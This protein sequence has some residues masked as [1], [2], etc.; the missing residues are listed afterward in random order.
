LDALGDAV[1]ASGARAQSEDAKVAFSGSSRFDEAKE[2][3]EKAISVDPNSFAAHYDLAR[4][5]AS[6]C[7][8]AVVHASLEA[9]ALKPA[10]DALPFGLAR[11]NL[12]LQIGTLVESGIEHAHRALEI[13]PNSSPAMQQLAGLLR[14]RADLD[15]TPEGSEA[16]RSL[17]QDWSRRAA[18]RSELAPQGEPR[19]VRIGARVAEANLTGRVDPVYPPLARAARVQG[20][21]EFTVTIDETGRVTDA[22]LVSGHPLLVQAAKEAVMQWMYRPTFL[23][24]QPVKVMTTVDVPFRLPE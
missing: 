21:V 9:G 17:S 19:F 14:I 16:D 4:I 1:Y 2:L 23:N 11:Q 12:R 15:E 7:V 22:K 3:L 8:P 10:G 5:I 20:T 13:E 6:Q 24:G 18:N